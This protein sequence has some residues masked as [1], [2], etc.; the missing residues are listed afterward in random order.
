MVGF[1]QRRLPWLIAAGA[2]LFY[3]CTLSRWVTVLGLAPLARAAGWDWHPV[4][5]APLQFLLTYPCRWLPPQLQ[6]IGLNLFSAI[7]AT[8][9]LA[10]LARSVA[11]LP[12]DR[13]RDQRQAQPSEGSFLTIPISWL[14]PLLAV[15]VC[16]L[17]M[18]FWEQAVVWTGEALDLLLF[19]YVIRCLLEYRID[20][21]D[22]WLLRLALVYGL[23]MTSNFAMIAFLPAL[24]IA[25]VWVKGLSF[26]QWRFCVR[27]VLCGLAGLSLYLVLPLFHTIVDL[28]DQSFWELLRLNL[29]FQKSA[30]FGF[31]RAVVLMLSFTS[32]MPVLFMGIKW[33][34]SFGDISAAGNI[35]TNLM[36]HV[37]HGVFLL[38]CVYVAFDPAYSPRNLGA[39]YPFLPLY[40]L[41][42]MSIG[43]FSGYFLLVFGTGRLKVWQ[44]PSILRTVLNRG[45]VVSVW[46]LAAAVPAGLVYKNLP[47][48]KS[49]QGPGLRQYAT[50]AAK[51]LPAQDSVVLSDDPL[52]LYAVYSVL[53]LDGSRRGKI[54][55]ESTSMTSPLYQRFLYEHHAPRWPQVPGRPR[56]S[57]EGIDSYTLT[58]MLLRLRQTMPL[59][60]LQPSFGYYFEHLY[61]KPRKLVCELKPCPTNAVEGP[62]LSADEKQENEQFWQEMKNQDLKP[63]LQALKPAKGKK[64][65]R[66]E[67][68]LGVLYSRAVDNFGVELQKSGDLEKAGEYFALALD[69]DPDSAS[70]MINRD[71]N[72]NLRA[73]NPHPLKRSDEVQKRLNRYAGNWDQ[74]LG[75]NG[76]VD[77]PAMCNDLAQVLVKGRNFR[78][79]AQQLLR[80]G[81]LTPTNIDARV[82]FASMCMQAGL[83]D[84]ALG[85][86]AEL[87]A[88][89]K[90]HTVDK[91]AL[92]QTEAW[93]YAAQNDVPAAEKVLQEAQARYPLDDLPYATLAEIYLRLGRITNAME[94]LDKELKA[95]PEN[96]TALNNAARLKILNKEYEA[97]VKFL[98]HAH[99][100]DPKS[101]IILMNRSICN[102]K[103]GKLDDAQ[104]DYQALENSV[105]KVPYTVYYGLF[106]IAFQK[107][108]PKTALKYGELYLKGAPKGTSEYKQV[109]ERIIK[110]K[111]GSF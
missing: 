7:C 105:P 34:A 63:L 104:R 106:D 45:V 13:T 90:L 93:T 109:T 80:V 56:K 65:Q 33:P 70:A 102:L 58:D 92:I 78:Q 110:V 74:L 96:S 38:A 39:P 5:H 53:Q 14:P 101:L 61:S 47:A 62:L 24:A 30:I 97:A 6:I 79:A 41:G 8:L 95:Q 50:L 77:E 2:L 23:A 18:T 72:Q 88:K 1:V 71:Y 103:S 4:L 107:K 76:P 99:S 48:L 43:Y 20:R 89:E 17:Q 68:L 98:D 40:Y 67:S 15:L 86:V 16:G 25:L 11:L 94:V 69:L 84:L 42:A 35:L 52:S 111:N 32:L 59:Y 44:R 10:L 55:V 46:I 66:A 31:P 26:F 81:Y 27:L 9:A 19:A 73:G 51:S 28:K 3:A 22:S 91:Q 57:T 12:H 75:H 37:I 29:G 64:P 108:N 54:L 82:G 87:R 36:T 100:L 49:S 83:L 21:R 60:Y 85:Y